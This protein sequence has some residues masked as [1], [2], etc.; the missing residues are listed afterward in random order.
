MKNLVIAEF[1]AQPGKAE[2]LTNIFNEAL[3]DTRA[4]DGCLSIDLYYEEKTNTFTMLE[5]WESLNHYEKYLQWR[6]DTGIQEV[7]DPVLEG[8]WDGVVSSIK[9]IMLVESFLSTN[10]NIL[11][12]II[13][14]RV[15]K[16]F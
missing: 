11:S 9:K 3:V 15:R 1:K 6:I 13:I 12:L 7:M 14:F 16:I 10:C 2:E 8:G 4:F 5:N